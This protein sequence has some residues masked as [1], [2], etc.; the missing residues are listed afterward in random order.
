MKVEFLRDIFNAG[1][2]IYE[3]GKVYEGDLE[4]YVRR[5][6]AVEANG[7]GAA[8]ASDQVANVRAGKGGKGGGKA[9]A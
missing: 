8:E 3:A 2:K 1:T 5:G 4:R 6:D 7:K 9:K